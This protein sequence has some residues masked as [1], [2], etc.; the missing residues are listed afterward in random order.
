MCHAPSTASR[1]NHRIMTGPNAA[2]IRV[3]PLLCTANR[4]TR[5]NTV[6]GTT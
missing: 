1:M 3:V 6:S 4:M 5:I 2:A